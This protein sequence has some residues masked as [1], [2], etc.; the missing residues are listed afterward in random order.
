MV[1]SLE[2]ANRFSRPVNLRQ[3]SEI[4]A[5]LY[6]NY[7]TV[8]DISEQ[9][10]LRMLVQSPYSKGLQLPPEVQWTSN[11]I[12]KAAEFQSKEIGIVHPY[13]YLTVRSGP[14]IH[15]RDGEWHVDG[16]SMRYTHLPEANYV[17]VFGETPTEWVN[18]YFDFPK[19]FDALKH[20]VHLFFQKRINSS[21]IKTLDSNTLYFMDPYV[22][23]RKPKIISG[24]I[25]CFVRISFTPIEIP[26]INNTVNPLISTAHYNYDGIKDFRDSLKDYD[27]ERIK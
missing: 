7:V 1:M 22:V 10:I 6:A 20:N 14:V 21:R 13:T 24:T 15:S 9:Y 26:D 19:D 23:H 18:Q 17:I 5:P 27:L 11:L 12:Q 8:R 16:F 2:H 25:R 4:N 3:F